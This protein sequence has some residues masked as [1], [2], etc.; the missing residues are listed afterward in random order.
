[1]RSYLLLLLLSN[2]LLLFLC[3]FNNPICKGARYYCGSDNS[4]NICINVSDTRQRVH[5]L[6]SCPAETYCPFTSN[7]TNNTIR[8][9]PK[10]AGNLTL[11]G[12]YCS[13]NQE[14][15][16]TNCEN[17]ICKGKLLEEKCTDHSDCDP[18]LFCNGTT[19]PDSRI[20]KICLKQVAFGEVKLMI[21]NMLLLY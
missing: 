13:N 20:Q 6:Q 8:C 3:S 10:P 5:Y 7:Y 11:P 14:C 18:G 17:G 15:L 9:I 12:E 2:L 21:N 19:Y 4:P 16:S 1:M